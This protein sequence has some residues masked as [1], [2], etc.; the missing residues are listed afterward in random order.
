MINI[1]K[2]ITITVLTGLALSGCGGSGSSGS[3][4]NTTDYAPKTA[5]AFEARFKDKVL[6][7]PSGNTMTI[8]TGSKSDHV[9]NIITLAGAKGATYTYGY[10]RKNTSISKHIITENT[11][12]TEKKI[13][14]TY[15]WAFSAELSGTMTENC[16]GGAYELDNVTTVANGNF[17]IE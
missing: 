16:A 6:T 4:G 12:T 5:T 17:T 7:L 14:C 11:G 8:R 10:T 1:Y 3:S 9:I 15:T 2:K 13:T